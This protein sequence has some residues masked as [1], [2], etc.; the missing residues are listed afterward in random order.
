MIAYCK[1]VF[2]NIKPHRIKPSTT[3]LNQALKVLYLYLILSV[4]GRMFADE[5]FH[6]RDLNHKGTSKFRGLNPCIYNY[7]I[8]RVGGR[9]VHADLPYEQKHLSLLL[10]MHRFTHLLIDDDH[11]QHKHQETTTLQSIIQQQY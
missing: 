9:L 7:G 2:V 10:Q 5:L 1:R 8:L 4:L 3:E 11:R 6:L